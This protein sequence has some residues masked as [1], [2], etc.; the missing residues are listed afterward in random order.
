MALEVSSAL[1]R[2]LRAGP[3]PGWATARLTN[4]TTLW[5]G[6]ADWPRPDIA[7]ED[8]TSGATLALEFKPPNQPKREYITGVGQMLTYLREFEFAGLVL[9]KKSSDGFAIS[10]YVKSMI[11]DDI[12]NL[13]LALFSYDKSASVLTV[14]RDLQD[15]I[16]SAPKRPARRGRGTFWAYWRD[17]SNYDV[18]SLLQ[19]IDSQ[20][21]PS[22]SSA[23]GSYWKSDVVGKKA[24]TWEG[25]LRKKKAKA[26]VTP[27]ERNAFYA[28]RHS[29]LV[30]PQ[31]QIT[32]PGLELL[33]VG[34]VYGPDSIAFLT[35]LARQI[36][37]DGQHLE[38]I[39]WVEKESSELAVTDK[40]NSAD[41]LTALDDRLVAE[42]VIPPRSKTAS[43]AHF[44]R[45]EPKLWNKLGLLH[46]RSTSDYFH[47]GLGYRFDWRKIISI[48]ESDRV[49]A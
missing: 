32:M 24:R 27:E 1:L 22:F 49:S 23:F 26:K 47:P 35:M 39:L 28:L 21:V 48:I 14:E 8:L 9:P 19:K 42:G 44:I 46:K 34:K 2:E 25:I 11:E 38:L 30:D 4:K 41:Y 43:K 40:G 7:F 36:L 18:F 33:H 45:D 5:Q 17:L 20:S 3:T 37:V 12:P 6:I 10:T 16:G 31:G 13:P 29:G 15:R